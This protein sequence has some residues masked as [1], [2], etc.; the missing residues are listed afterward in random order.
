MTLIKHLVAVTDLEATILQSMPGM[1]AWER[2]WV[3][4]RHQAP[5]DGLQVNQSGYQEDH[6]GAYWLPCMLDRT[7]LEI[8]Y[9][10]LQL[11]QRIHV[12]V[13]KSGQRKKSM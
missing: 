4:A 7:V 6:L 11:S 2:A 12:D 9:E 10:F 1:I 5:P 8:L 3:R 13:S